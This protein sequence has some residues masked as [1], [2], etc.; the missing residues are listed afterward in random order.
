MGFA[1]FEKLVDA[2]K[3]DAPMEVCL[4]HCEKK[5]NILD[6]NLDSDLIDGQTAMG[7]CMNEESY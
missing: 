4:A 2:C 1:K 3:W 6:F 5:A 7:E